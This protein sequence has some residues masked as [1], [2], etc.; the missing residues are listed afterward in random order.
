[1]NKLDK[2]MMD[3]ML[4]KDAVVAQGKHARYLVIHKSLYDELMSEF[5]ESLAYS[6]LEASF[7]SKVEEL[8][9]EIGRYDLK[10]SVGMLH[11]LHM[12]LSDVM[13]EDSFL[14]A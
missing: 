3:I 7:L 14:I 12:I 2:I 4:Q 6:E 8:E 9:K 11:G 10:V 5:K 1:M 13:D